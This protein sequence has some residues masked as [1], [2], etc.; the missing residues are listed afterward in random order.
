MFVGDLD[1][2]AYSG[3]WDI[4]RRHVPSRACAYCYFQYHTMPFI[5]DEWH[6]FFVCPLYSG[7]RAKL[8]FTADDVLVE[9]H[10]IQGSG[11]TPRNLQSLARAILRVQNQNVIAGFLMNAFKARRQYRTSHQ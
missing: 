6:V 5:E 11:C 8:P 9:G 10:S 2:G 7:F 4:K 1:I 3:N